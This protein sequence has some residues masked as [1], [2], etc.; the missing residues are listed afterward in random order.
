MLNSVPVPT[1]TAAVTANANAV[2]A[3]QKT[4]LTQNPFTGQHVNISHF[5]INILTKPPLVHVYLGS[6]ITHIHYFI[7]TG[8]PSYLQH[9]LVNVQFIYTK[10]S[11]PEPEV[12]LCRGLSEFQGY[13]HSDNF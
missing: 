11:R 5:T 7:I 8:P 10:C 9:N 3:M 12:I 13:C 6:L 1:A 2:T 4:L